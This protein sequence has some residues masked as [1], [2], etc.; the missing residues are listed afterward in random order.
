MGYIAPV[1]ELFLYSLFV[2]DIDSIHYC[3]VLKKA[4]AFL[5]FWMV[6][7]IFCSYFKEFWFVLLLATC[8]TK[9]CFIM[10][11]SEALQNDIQTAMQPMPVNHMVGSDFTN[12]LFLVFSCG[13]WTK[14]NFVCKSS[15]SRMTV[16]IVRCTRNCLPKNVHH[17]AWE[18]IHW[19]RRLRMDILECGLTVWLYMSLC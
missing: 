11:F 1:K 7:T 4:G 15:K 2:C 8:H 9:H 16:L 6:L 10:R 5:C 3:G 17:G 12:L 14:W 18:G 19:K 13:F